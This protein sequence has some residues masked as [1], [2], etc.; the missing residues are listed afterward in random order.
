M[1][2]LFL[3][4]ST[5]VSDINNRGIYP[6]LLRKFAFEGH[7]VF[8]V[9]SFERKLRKQT[10]YI[11]YGSVHILGVKTLNIT[12]TNIFEKG[13][14]TLLI[15]YQFK[16]AINKY[17]YNYNFDLILYST[18]PITFSN[19]I[20]YLKIKYQAKS[21]LLLKDIFPQNAVDLGLIRKNGLIHKFFKKKKKTVI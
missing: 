7:E 14:S 15:E 5:A 20:N 11:N 21:Y 19:L 16:N 2:I 1:N 13:I 10:N 8:I 3:S 9:C 18:P 12:K 17:F 6:D 4:I